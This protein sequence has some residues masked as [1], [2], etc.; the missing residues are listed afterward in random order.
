MLQRDKETT[1]SYTTVRRRLHFLILCIIPAFLGIS[2]ESVAEVKTKLHDLPDVLLAERAS[3][4]SGSKNDASVRML[5]R[6]GKIEFGPSEDEKRRLLEKTC[7]TGDC[8]GL[9]PASLA[10]VFTPPFVPDSLYCQNGFQFLVEKADFIRRS[11]DVVYITKSMGATANPK[12]E[13]CDSRF[14]R[15]NQLVALKESKLKKG[16]FSLPPE[17]V[18][19]A[20]TALLAEF[21]LYEKNLRTEY[22]EHGSLDKLSAGLLI[23]QRQLIANI[24]LLPVNVLKVEGDE[25]NPLFLLHGLSAA[26]S[27]NLP[28]EV[29]FSVWL[30]STTNGWLAVGAAVRLGEANEVLFPDEV[31][32]YR[33]AKQVRKS[34]LT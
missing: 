7:Q 17:A 34:F 23:E 13:E 11:N 1:H 24:H 18:S 14:M 2:A 21:D 22:L 12:S 3:K 26:D 10:K 6:N 33:E 25:R 29:V 4:K 9:V 28:A 5:F 16:K 19:A 31:P 30:T 8:S 27:D 20:R 32:D 15:S